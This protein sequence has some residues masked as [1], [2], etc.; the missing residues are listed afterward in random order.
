VTGEER[1]RI[2]SWFSE[3]LKIAMD[4]T[5]C[6]TSADVMAGS[7]GCAAQHEGTVWL[8]G[9]G[10]GQWLHEDCFAGSACRHAAA[11]NSNVNRQMRDANLCS[12]LFSS[13]FIS[14]VGRINLRS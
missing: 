5:G 8:C 7:C 6:F 3:G 14:T 10:F 1:K 2:T 4:G 9:A 11:L 12:I 13:F